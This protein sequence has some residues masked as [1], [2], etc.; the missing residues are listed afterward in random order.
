[1]SRF[2]LPG[3]IFL[4]LLIVIPLALGSSSPAVPSP[5]G[6]R[7]EEP[8]QGG[9]L[10]VGSL[11]TEEFRATF[12]PAA[13]APAFLL[14]QV[15]DG[16]VKLDSNL[17]IV[18]ALAE[19][20]VISEDGKTY[21][22]F[23]RQG[24]KFHHGRELEARDVKFSLERLIRGDSPGPHARHFFGKVLGA[25]EFYD[26]RADGVAGIR[27]R[28]RSTLEIEWL[29]PEVATLYL[30]SMPFCKILPR[31]LVLS[32]GRGFFLKPSGT[33]PFRFAYWLRN[34]RLEVVGARLERNEGYFGRKP[35]LE[36][37]EFSPFYTLDHFLSGEV[38]ILPYTSERLA[39][40]GCRVLEDES[41]NPVY[42]GM[43]CHIPPLDMTVVRRALAMAVNKKEIARAAFRL[44]TVPRVTDNFIPAKLPG[45][46]PADRVDAYR[47]EE[48]KALLHGEGLIGAASFPPFNLF[49]ERPKRD[50]DVK[51][52][53]VLRDGLAG[54][55]IRLN[56]EYFDSP[57]ELKTLNDP[58]FIVIRSTMEYPDPGN[59]VTS[60]FFSLS[61]RNLETLHYSSRPLDDLVRKTEA[62][63]SWTER[64]ALF[65][66][67]EALLNEDMPAVPLYSGDRRLAV[68]P[69]VRGLAAPPFGFRHLQVKE[70]W[71][72]K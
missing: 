3:R 45:F 10:R 16:L 35:Y 24:I 30:L 20:W 49:F 13:G 39:D 55:G 9:T 42:L 26:G 57:D 1:M 50:E 69:R 62:E 43:S 65:R 60:L 63:R 70:V 2:P 52:Y 25:Q 29:K 61:Q 37:V 11:D 71:L 68:Q 21:T 38:D 15:F 46:F 58:Y 23:L 53:R 59:L 5:A 22:F 36:A 72:A 27:V 12:D 66:R 51:I 18:P 33:G 67:I 54:L 14:E 48:A 40:S 47:P 64:T 19:Y 8:L 7:A 4:P 56:L 17:G 32:K 34:T 31:E 44:D 41:F 28:D 6:K